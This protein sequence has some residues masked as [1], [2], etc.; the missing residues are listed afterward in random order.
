MV[1]GLVQNIR[2]ALKF[3]GGWKGKCTGTDHD[4]ITSNKC[5]MSFIYFILN[6]G[7]MRPHG[8]T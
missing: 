8:M 2:A 4:Y 6:L 7:D 3:R 5:L 1:V